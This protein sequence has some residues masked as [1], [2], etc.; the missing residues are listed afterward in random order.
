MKNWNRQP[1]WGHANNDKDL[2]KYF[3]KSISWRQWQCRHSNAKC[4]F[5]LSSSSLCIRAKR[6]WR[7]GEITDLLPS[8]PRGGPSQI[9]QV[10]AHSPNHLPF[11]QRDQRLS[12]NDPPIRDF[13]KIFSNY[14]V[15]IQYQPL[16]NTI[17]TKPPS[18]SYK[19]EKKSFVRAKS[20]AVSIHEASP[21]RW[22]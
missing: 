4:G 11:H 17:Y 7:L 14:W 12:R 2:L 18:I 22:R 1:Y 10:S 3:Q 21:H 15:T 19:R 6:L 20:I 13:R 16:I 5:V 9:P 8:Q